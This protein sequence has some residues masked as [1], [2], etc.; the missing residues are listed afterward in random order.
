MSV[1]CSLVSSDLNDN[2]SERGLSGFPSLPRSNLASENL[3]RSSSGEH[4]RLFTLYDYL[5]GTAS[6]YKDTCAESSIST[7]LR[8]SETVPVKESSLQGLMLSENKVSAA[9]FSY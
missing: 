7:K 1:T 3:D 8:G 4:H 6:A 2:S 9:I 5:T